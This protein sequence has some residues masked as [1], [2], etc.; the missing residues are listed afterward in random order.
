LWYIP[1]ELVDD[2][3]NPT[4]ELKQVWVRED[5]SL[6]KDAE[7]AKSES[8]LELDTR[9]AMVVGECNSPY[10]NLNILDTIFLPAHPSP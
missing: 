2:P 6:R 4:P 5:P 8:L 1:K 3:D 9:E 7:D 10:R